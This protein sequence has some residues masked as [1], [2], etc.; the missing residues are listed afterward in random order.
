MNQILNVTCCVL[1]QRRSERLDSR[2]PLMQ[3]LFRRGIRQPNVTICV[4][5]AKVITRC[6]RDTGVAEQL[7]DSQEDFEN[8]YA[9]E[10]GQMVARDS[11][12]NVLKRERLFVKEH[13]II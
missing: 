5:I 1:R 12:S 6:E 11:I 10:I 8:A 3:I 4:F 13:D 9:S 7:F 2:K